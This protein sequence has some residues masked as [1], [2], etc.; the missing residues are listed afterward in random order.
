MSDFRHLRSQPQTDPECAAIR[1]ELEAWALAA[2]EPSEHTSVDQHLSACSGCRAEADRWLQV[3]AALPL[4][5]T[6]VAPSE[7]TKTRL[8]QRIASDQMQAVTPP[9][10]PVGAEDRTGTG[11]TA[12]PYSPPVRFSWS[13]IIVAPLILALIVM[14]VWSFNLQDQVDSLE[15]DSA[16]VTA[17]DDPMLPAGVQTFGMRSECQQCASDGRILAN[18]QTDN[19]LFVAWNLDPGMVH[20]VW[21]VDG[22]GGKQMVASLNVSPSGDVVQPLLFDEPISGYSQIYVMSRN[23]GVEQMMEMSDTPM[24]TPV[25]DE[26]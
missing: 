26:A 23:D 25:P 19:A 4:S 21:C 18:P 6:P 16:Q 20:Q 24:S 2:L 7:A 14:T 15:G 1:D 9:L 13:Q 8:M 12:A 17:A 5:L 22:Q 11:T 10:P 3:T